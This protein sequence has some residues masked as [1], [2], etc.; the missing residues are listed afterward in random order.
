MAIDLF[1]GDVELWLEQDG[2]PTPIQKV[3]GPSASFVESVKV[4]IGLFK[5]F[6]I[7]VHLIPPIENAVQLLKSGKVGIGFS[8]KESGGQKS[9]SILGLP[10]IPNFSVNANRMWVRLRYGGKTSPY[11]KSILLSP[12]VDVGVDGINVTLKG[13][14]LLY[15]STKSHSQMNVE[16]KTRLQIIQDLLGNNV[17]VVTRDQRAKD[18]L[19]SVEH[20]VLS[21]PDYESVHE[22]VKKSNCIMYYTGS[23]TLNGKQKVIIKSVDASRKNPEGSYK[24][25]AP[26]FVAYRQ[27]DPNKNIF[28]LLSLRCPID[29]LLLPG[30]IY[31]KKTNT[32]QR[33]TKTYKTGRVGSNTVSEA[34]DKISSG[35]GSV[36]GVS[37]GSTTVHGDT[38]GM[39]NPDDV[40]T[41]M[42]VLNRDGSHSTLDSIKGFIHS[43]MSQVFEYEATSIGV[44]DLL[45]GQIVNYQV[46]DIK[47][48]SGGYDLLEVEHNVSSGGIETAMKSIRTGGLASGISEKLNPVNPK[49]PTTSAAAGNTKVSKGLS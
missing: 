8:V 32:F 4:T 40:G 30:G 33:D 49:T 31:G 22:L 18:A 44:V 6:N 34:S 48:L 9:S 13:V 26:T 39:E 45:P 46:E 12:D 10:S 41:N 16:G 23:D 25:G 1:S 14:G 24:N 35:D 15:E 17:E 11:F 20:G 21:K 43:Y 7:E 47:P 36:A 37:L 3:I 29:H 27:I 19:G 5:I 42:S 2:Q 28:P 38:A